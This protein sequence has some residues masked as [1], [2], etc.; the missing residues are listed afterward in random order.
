MAELIIELESKFIP[1]GIQCAIVV[2]D[3]CDD[4]L[5]DAKPVDA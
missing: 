5:V 4:I 2:V 1:V 3:T